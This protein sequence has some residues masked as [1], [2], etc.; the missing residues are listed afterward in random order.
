MD[1][2]E[3][4]VSFSS[5]ETWRAI[6]DG[7]RAA[8]SLAALFSLRRHKKAVRLVTATWHRALRRALMQANRLERVRVPAKMSSMALR[9]I[10]HIRAECIR[11][12]HQGRP[13]NTEVYTL[14][15]PVT[16]SYGKN[17]TLLYPWTKA[18]TQ[19]A[20]DMYDRAIHQL[21]NRAVRW[22]VAYNNLAMIVQTICRSDAL[23]LVQNTMV[24]ELININSD[25]DH[26]VLQHL[27]AWP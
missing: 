18:K 26:G 8:D 2:D 3:S 17:Q 21:I 6:D 16:P 14:A 25:L 9:R 4:F 11:V 19:R 15:C 12:A 27:P 13:E 24:N 7:N 10:Q 20:L 23:F 1:T 5:G 22:L